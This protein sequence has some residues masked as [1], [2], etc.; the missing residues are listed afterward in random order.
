MPVFSRLYDL[1]TSEG[2]NAP[3]ITLD[4]FSS[5]GIYG[6]RNRDVPFEPL[7]EMCRSHPACTY[8]GYQP[9]AV[10]RRAL[11]RSDIFA[12]PSI[13]KE[14]SCIAAIEA[15][16][17]GLDVVT[18]SLA[19]LPETLG[20]VGEEASQYI[21]TFDSDKSTHARV[22]MQ[23]L[24]R[25]IR[26]FEV[27]E[28]EGG[29]IRHCRTSS[30]QLLTDHHIRYNTQEPNAR[31]RRRQQQIRATTAYTWGY[32]GFEGRIEDWLNTLLAVYVKNRPFENVQWNALPRYVR[33]RVLM[34]QGRI[35]AAIE[36]LQSEEAD[37]DPHEV[38]ALSMDEMRVPDANLRAIERI[39]RLLNASVLAFEER[40]RRRRRRQK[41]GIFE[42]E[43][44]VTRRETLDSMHTGVFYG[45]AARAGWY[46]L[47]RH[48]VDAGMR[49]FDLAA[50]SRFPH[51]DCWNVYMSTYVPHIPRNEAEHDLVLER[52]KTYLDTLIQRAKGEDDPPILE[53]PKCFSS[54]FPIAYYDTNYKEELSRWVTAL[55]TT[56][57]N[58]LIWTAPNLRKRQRRSLPSRARKLRVA[59]VSSHF[60]PESSIWGSF[61]ATINFLQVHGDMDVSM[62]YHDESSANDAARRLSMRPET[63]LYLHMGAGIVN[64]AAAREA[65]ARRRFDVLVYLDLFMTAEMHQLAVARLAPVQAYTHGHPV[66]SGVSRDTMDYYISWAAAEKS[67]DAN[68]LHYTEN[69]VMLPGN[70]PWEFW[71]PR[72]SDDERSIVGAN[73]S[74]AEYDTKEKLAQ[75]LPREFGRML[76]AN[77]NA[78]LYFCAQAPF[79]FHLTFDR[80]LAA[81]QRAD[82]N[83]V[84]VLIAMAGESLE[85]LNPRIRRRL[86]E[87]GG[88]DLERVVFVPR[89]K[90]YKLMSAYKNADVVLDSVYFG[91][92]TTTR[93]AFE[94]GAP[95]VTLP[96]RTIGQRWTQAY[97]RLMGEGLYDELVAKDPNDYVRIATRVANLSPAQKRALRGRIRA[98]AKSKLY[99]SP[100]AAPAWANV[101]LKI[102][103]T[104]GW[105]WKDEN[106]AHELRGESADF[107]A[108]E[109]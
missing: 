84:I 26:T 90:H 73:V 65:I 27:R 93:E 6:W 14:T 78:T 29:G 108:W 10:V 22:F 97:Y 44:S 72:T 2:K 102:G 60:S 81:I 9:N 1:Y 67:S 109:L 66:T 61:G 58:R 15:L 47:S 48:Y 83:A 49:W 42:E 45:L 98:A 43:K 77:P 33:R 34:Q 79:K 35:N 69:L 39:E 62:V 70:A 28:D 82:P 99:M 3:N 104:P 18:S 106:D 107:S 30:C 12:Y 37:L 24:D 88:V 53:G 11:G 71:I 4:V 52:Y 55:I 105:E 59:F 16:C 5:F 13:W 23:T 41:T 21:Y 56:M 96:H 17:A 51:T 95:V 32:R 94:T 75:L 31:L 7:F 85:A 25:A 50:K 64:L 54:A 68:R 80:I 103:S 74:F 63:N 101:L 92:D 87:E 40:R 20:V 86:V 100:H 46:R 36:M 57:P 76:D 19:A 91:G 89:M 8:H 38:V